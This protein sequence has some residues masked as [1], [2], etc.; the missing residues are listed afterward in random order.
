MRI[1]LIKFT[2]KV[3]SKILSHINGV[4]N[5]ISFFISIIRSLKTIKFLHFR[6]IYN[7]VV[8]Q[9]FFTGLGAMPLILIIALLFGGTVIIQATKNFPKFGIEG[10]IGNLLVV[11]ITRE[12]GPLAAAMIVT[13]RSGSAIA[14][15]IATQKLNNEIMSLELMGI[16]TKLY[17]V[18]PRI[19]AFVLSIFSLMLIFNLAAFLGGYVISQTTVYIPIGEFLESIM[20]ATNF[21]D[22]TITMLKST[23]YGAMIP[24]ICCYYGFKPKSLFEIPIYVSKAVVR[25]LLILFSINALIS[26]FFYF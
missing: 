6:S 11:I 18:I 12:I 14:A 22:L 8:N 13:S 17:I 2:I 1:K 23:I 16:D 26:A 19:I 15:E 7:I 4:H 24:V 5:F 9:T 25:T 20:S 10:Y 21:E 3:G